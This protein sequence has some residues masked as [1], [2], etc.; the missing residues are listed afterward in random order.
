[1]KFCGSGARTGV[2][3]INHSYKNYQW[4]EWQN[5]DVLTIFKKHGK[6]VITVQYQ[7]IIDESDNDLSRICS[8]RSVH[9]DCNSCT[10]DEFFACLDKINAKG[11]LNRLISHVKNAVIGR[12]KHYA[13]SKEVIEEITPTDKHAED[14]KQIALS[15]N[16]D[17]MDSLEVPF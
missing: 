15:D 8:F 2:S 9:P 7:V 14:T 12:K 17:E 4:T 6:D 1:M 3:M 13:M 5:G 16:I 10:N 11:N